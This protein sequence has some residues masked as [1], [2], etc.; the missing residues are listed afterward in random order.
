MLP[1]SLST[2]LPPATTPG[3]GPS[4]APSDAFSAAMA[5]ALTLPAPP[6]DSKASA[7]GERQ[8]TADDGKSLPADADASPD[9][10]TDSDRIDPA[11]AWLATPTPVLVSMPPIAT[12][13][14]RAGRPA[15]AAPGKLTPDQIAAM[16]SPAVPHVA[17]DAA[18]PPSASP[19]P[20][21]SIT[22]TSKPVLLSSAAVTLPM[23][24]AT[25]AAPVDK[26]IAQAPKIDAIALP[27]TPL[28]SSMT[29]PRLAPMTPKPPLLTVSF[30]SKLGGTAA[31]TPSMATPLS[32]SSDVQLST[33]GA[34]TQPTLASGSGSLPQPA[35]PLQRA[36]LLE[37]ATLVPVDAITTTRFV[38]AQT[39]QPRSATDRPAAEP[40]ATIAA[41]GAP[42]APTIA[43]DRATRADAPPRVLTAATLI[44][45]NTVVAAPLTINSVP[46]PQ[47]IAPVSVVLAPADTS[48]R[49]AHETLATIT[50]KGGPAAP[51]IAP[52]RAANDAPPA[53]K[54]AA[55]PIQTVTTAAAPLTS[56]SAP[57]P[58]SAAPL[59]IALPAVGMPTP[60]AR[61]VASVVRDA[62][63]AVATP[64]AAQ[65]VPV[66]APPAPRSVAQP[67]A[68]AFGQAIATVI[69][70]ERRAKPVLDDADPIL[71]NAG[72]AG[73]GLA[74]QP[75]AAVAALSGAQQA[76]LDMHRDDWPQAMI[77]RIE[78]FRDAAD[79]NDTRIRLVPD[80]LGKIDVSLRHDSDGVRVHFAAEMPATQQLLTNAQ[81][82]L[83]ELAQARGLR[84]G[85]G[86]IA[87]D[88]G[89]TG[90]HHQGAATPPPAQFTRPA[91][92]AATIAGADADT[93]LA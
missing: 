77:D 1:L 41:K 58:L 50:I 21:R 60:P 59:N 66:A 38:P 91:S 86:G 72:L 74:T 22:T 64:M 67:A 90:Q 49:P 80:A 34:N 8:D 56:N 81:P 46:A 12:D 3:A 33:I 71:P 88:A 27:V 15:A 2:I 70:E 61:P 93:R 14:P 87:S 47:F 37:P 31:P 18:S 42:P 43:A 84:L 16:M 89:N 19:T 20:S 10:A 65:T 26:A 85:Q 44:Q 55:A 28:A 9:D 79:A 17:V 73:A 7:A 5:D 75:M 32:M 36:D 63:G 35:S 76:P 52:D 11:F 40:L 68:I 92:A 69:A 29:H 13:A 82:K 23:Q 54:T 78:A 6:P 25:T 51:T 53:E 83:A 45:P 57:A 48:S 62:A 39:A 4:P 30:P 24:N